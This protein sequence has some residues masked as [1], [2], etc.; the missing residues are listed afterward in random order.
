[1]LRGSQNGE[2][3]ADHGKE[4]HGGPLTACAHIA[5][6]HDRHYRGVSKARPRGEG[7]QAAMRRGD[8]HGYQQEDPERDIEAEPAIA[9]SYGQGS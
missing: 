4:N 7:D 9:V 2:G 8:P 3:Y 5:D 6:Y 1:L